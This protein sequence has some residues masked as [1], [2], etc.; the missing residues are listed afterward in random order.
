MSLFIRS[1]KRHWFTTIPP[2]GPVSLAGQTVIVTGG[3]D[4]IGY[5]VAKQLAA[6]HPDK[7][8]LA[9]RNVSKSEA[10]I[11]QI[12]NAVD[13]SNT[14]MEAWK[15]DLGSIESVKKFAARANRE[16]ERLDILVLN[17]GVMRAQFK[18]TADGHEE[19]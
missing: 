3:N 8:I 12:R 13:D 4:G 10:A 18:L 9:S 6:L 1:L 16:L 15:L 14:T 5:Q 2:V 7:L 17:A 19:T 11:Q